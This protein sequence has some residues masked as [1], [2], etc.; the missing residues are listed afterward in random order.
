M[1]KN[2]IIKNIFFFLLANFL[3]FLNL[4]WHIIVN[5][6]FNLLNFT[7]AV[8]LWVIISNP[9][10]NYW[11][12]ILYVAFVNELFEKTVFGITFL[13]LIFTL[14]FVHWLLLNIFT[15][16]SLIT[17]FLSG[18]SAVVFYRLLFIGSNFLYYQSLIYIAQLK[19][20]LTEALF[21]A[22][23]LSL[24]YLISAFFIKHLH[25][26]YIRHGHIL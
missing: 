2:K 16:R 22:I 21:T 1:I 25:P 17:V 14:L 12:Y 20:F 9:R 3:I 26:E 24:G 11:P 8:L 7:L 19:L 13:P 15:N 23:A 4:S 10:G 5:P 6:A 18:F